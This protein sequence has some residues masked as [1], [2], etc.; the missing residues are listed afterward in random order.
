MKKLD[1][2]YDSKS[3]ATRVFKMAELMSIKYTT[4]SDYIS[5]QTDRLAGLLEQLR[6][7]ESKT[8]DTFYDAVLVASIQVSELAPVTAEIKTLAQT[9]LKWDTVSSRLI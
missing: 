7:M 1:A 9:N 6:G 5:Q 8:G 4:V 3:I 2:R